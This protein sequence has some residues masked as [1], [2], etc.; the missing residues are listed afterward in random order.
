MPNASAYGFVPP[1]GTLFGKLYSVVNV[2]GQ[3][4]SV[5]A[6]T[7]AMM[8]AL[9]KKAREQEMIHL[10]YLTV[11]PRDY[12]GFPFCHR[13][14]MYYTPHRVHRSRF[15]HFFHPSGSCRCAKVLEAP[16]FKRVL[17]QL[18]VS[19]PLRSVCF[20]PEA[21]P[22]STGSAAIRPTMLPSNRRV[23][24]PSASVSQ[25]YRACFTSLPPVTGTRFPQM[26]RAPYRERPGR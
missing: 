19:F 6:V 3:A 4:M 15:S 8:N 7:A 10:L 13:G 11:C 12:P 20:P 18:S 22:V 2:W 23:R 9:R 16:R 1:G 26:S 5:P 17:R 21:Y 24:W 25:R 14:W